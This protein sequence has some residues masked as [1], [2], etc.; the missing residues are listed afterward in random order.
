M[1]YQQLQL[2]Y[3]E[4]FSEYAKIDILIKAFEI[5]N[6]LRLFLFCLSFRR[7]PSCQAMKKYP[8]Y[9]GYIAEALRTLSIRLSRIVSV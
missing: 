3:L 4:P 9:C 7:V 5:A 6:I 1:L 8:E 2:A